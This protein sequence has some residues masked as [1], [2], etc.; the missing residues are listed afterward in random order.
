MRRMAS[1][2][3]GRTNGP[4]IFGRPSVNQRNVPLLDLS[5]GKLLCQLAMRDVVLGY[6]NQAAGLFVQ[7]MY[8]AG[9]HLAA[10]IRELSET[11]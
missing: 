2:E 10:D 3:I 6:D 8:D 1:R 4:A 5:T 7:A 9:T 11:V